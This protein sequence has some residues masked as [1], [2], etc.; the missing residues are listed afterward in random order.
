MIANAGGPMM[1][2][3]LVRL[4]VG[5]VAFLG[6]VAWFFFLVNLLKVPLSAG[7]GLITAHSLVISA[8]LVPGIVA[9]ALVGRRLVLGMSRAVFENTALIATAAAGLWLL[10]A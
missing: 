2:L 9:G 4:G 10:V 8:T 1:T 5:K 7:L 6:T 3:Y